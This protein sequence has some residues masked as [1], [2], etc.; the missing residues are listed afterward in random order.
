MP[1]VLLFV[2]DAVG[3]TTL[4]YLLDHYA[5]KI[6]LPNLAQLGLGTLLHERFRDRIRLPNGGHALARSILQ[7]SRDADSVIGHREMMGVIDDRHYELFPNGFPRPYIAELER[8]IDRKT[9]FNR[10]AGGIEA[11]EQNAVEHSPTGYPI[12]YA[13]R[14]DPLIQIAMDEAVIPVTEQ[15]RIVQ[16]AFDLAQEMGVQITRAIARAY[17]RKDD[18]FARTANRHDVVLP[19]GRATLVDV[20][21]Q[22]KVRT[23]SVGKPADLLHTRLDETI[24][25][26]DPDFLDP[27][28]HLKFVHP[29]KKD[30][31]PFVFQ[32]VMN[33]LA[34]A[35]AYTPR[36]TFI[37]ANAVDTDSLWGHTRDVEGALHSLE[38]TDRMIPRFQKA[39]RG[40]DLLIVTADHGMRHEPDT[41]AGPG[42]G[43]HNKE[44]VPLLVW[45]KSSFGGGKLIS[46][47]AGAFSSL[48]EVGDLVAQMFQCRDIYRSSTFIVRA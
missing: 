1:T 13:S 26:T 9:L 28:L 38:E 36:G 25:L 37:F 20:L 29:D 4:E 31:N 12:V 27:A 43:F 11:I 30:V 14:C 39:M 33:A 47:E 22:L 19:I 5:E 34:H 17:V 24:N 8:R 3:L 46:L 10:M 40:G 6:N 32:G 15:H 2:I 21:R 35:R 23:V 16:V 18:G 42:Y 41:D 7:A 44:P 45:C 48:L